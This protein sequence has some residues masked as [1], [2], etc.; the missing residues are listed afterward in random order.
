MRTILSRVL[1]FSFFFYT[2]AVTGQINI[3][4]STFNEMMASPET[5]NR[6]VVS[7]SGEVKTIVM[8]AEL[9]D[10][11]NGEIIISTKS[12][13]VS[14]STGVNQIIPNRLFFK[15]QS[16]GQNKISS[17]VRNQKRLPSGFFEYCL[18]IYSNDG[19]YFETSKCWSYSNVVNEYLRLTS[20]RNADTIDTKLPMLSW[21]TSEIAELSLGTKDYRILVSEKDSD[22]DAESALNTN[23]SIFLKDHLE[24]LTVPY[25]QSAKELKPL[26][27]YAWR[28]EVLVDGNVVDETET[29][30]F[31]IAGEEEKESMKY[32]TV[33]RNLGGTPYQVYDN[34]IFFAF[35]ESYFGESAF[36]KCQIRADNGEVIENPIEHDTEFSNNQVGVDSELAEEEV[37]E[38]VHGNNKYLLDVSRYNLSPG[39]YSLEVWN[40]KG[41]MK[42]LLFEIQP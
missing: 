38:E 16:Y 3:L 26:K 24:S 6:I 37:G 33:R 10:T 25:P 7:V 15:S 8:E 4:S 2:A 20:P 21:T 29:W 11:D 22:E 13:P 30:Y 32:A 39:T 23:P 19:E 17:Y 9:V 28:V 12:N 18:N 27:S 5:M 1:T 36:P 14:V 41:E 31:T 40:Y 42:K 35:E 34:K